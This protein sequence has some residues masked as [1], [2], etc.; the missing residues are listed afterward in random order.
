MPRTFRLRGAG[1]S[2]LA[3]GAALCASAA[4]RAAAP[5]AMPAP[6]LKVTAP[7]ELSTWCRALTLS[8]D[9]RLLAALVDRRKNPRKVAGGHYCDLEIYRLG[10]EKPKASVFAM[11]SSVGACQFSSDGKRL[12]LLHDNRGRRPP[13]AR[14]ASYTLDVFDVAMGKVVRS[15]ELPAGAGYPALLLPDDRTLALG[16]VADAAVLFDLKEEKVIARLRGDEKYP[17]DFPKGAEEKPETR[18]KFVEHFTGKLAVSRDGKLLAVS[19]QGG[20][21]SVWDI[22]KSKRLWREYDG[23][24]KRV[25]E[26]HLSLTFS[27]DGA[28][29][30]SQRQG[31]D[32][33][34][35]RDART[36]KQR[37]AV[38]RRW[39]Y[40]AEYLP[41]GSMIVNRGHVRWDTDRGPYGRFGWIRWEPVENKYWGERWD[42]PAGTY[43][44]PRE[45]ILDSESTLMAVSANGHTLALYA[46]RAGLVAYDLTKFWP[47]P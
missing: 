22:A 41:D 2:L 43:P 17:A 31:S 13:G 34:Y 29:L 6:I 20:W 40:F 10:T 3:L 19:T 14:W 15:V 27:P 44:I 5:P 37:F 4:G 18:W 38:E 11:A 7:E 47:R 23:D 35:F 30:A 46:R 36:G 16:G 39:G 24:P 42:F 12:N 33:Q 1:A 45:A 9:G 8:P 21:A 25:P 26:P 28:T 32:V